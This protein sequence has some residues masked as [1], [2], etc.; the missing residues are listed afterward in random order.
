MH[1]ASIR[2]DGIRDRRRGETRKSSKQGGI[3]VDVWGDTGQGIDGL[4][5]G[6]RRD[7]RLRGGL[8]L[9]LMISQLVDSDYLSIV[10]KRNLAKNRG[11]DNRHGI[12]VALPQ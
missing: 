8:R 7:G 5:I 6:Y 2:Q 10:R 9:W 1:H 4:L 12:G 11:W 3:F